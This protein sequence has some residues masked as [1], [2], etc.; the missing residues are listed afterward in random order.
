MNIRKKNP[1]SEKIMPCWS[2]VLE[3]DGGLIAEYP[4]VV[5]PHHSLNRDSGCVNTLREAVGMNGSLGDSL[6]WEL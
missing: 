2:I 4:N 5:G 3:A 6:S 1:S